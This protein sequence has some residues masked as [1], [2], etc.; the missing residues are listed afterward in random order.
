MFF[1][2][3]FC[4]ILFGLRPLLA[5]QYFQPT[6]SKDWTTEKQFSLFFNFAI[7]ATF[8][9]LYNHTSFLAV[10]SFEAA[11]KRLSSITNDSQSKERSPSQLQRLLIH[12]KFH[13]CANL[14]EGHASDQIWLHH[15]QFANGMSPAAHII[16]YK[17]NINQ[18]KNLK[19]LLI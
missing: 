11:T 4:P 2:S 14:Q 5:H 1:L 7:K 8:V 9:S 12:Y 17:E 15:F 13:L 16:T 3:F 10:T 18:H 6:N 19:L